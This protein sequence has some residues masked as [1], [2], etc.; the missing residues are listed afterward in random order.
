MTKTPSRDRVGRSSRKARTVESGF[1]WSDSPE[2][3]AGASLSSKTEEE[4][5]EQYREIEAA[6][7]RARSAASTYYLG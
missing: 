1:E 2:A 7:I 6:Q 3:V 5:R 4:L